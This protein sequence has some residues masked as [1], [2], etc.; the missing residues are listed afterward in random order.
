LKQFGVGL[1]GMAL[2]CFGLAH[3]TVAASGACIPTGSPCRPKALC[4]SLYCEHGYC[5]CKPS[6]TSCGHPKQ[7]CSGVCSGLGLTHPGICG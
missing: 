6:G 3:S 1:A 2:A 4:C 5:A 7:C